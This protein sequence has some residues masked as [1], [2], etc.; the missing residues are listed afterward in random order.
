M[1]EPQTRGWSD[2]MTKI[3]HTNVKASNFMLSKAKKDR[4]I[5]IARSEEPGDPEDD[6]EVVDDDGQAKVLQEE[7][8]E[9]DENE[10]KKSSNKK[11]KKNNNNQTRIRP[12][13][14][15]MWNRES[16]LNA[17]ATKGVV[18]LFNAVNQHRKLISKSVASSGKSE[19]KRD[20]TLG[21]FSADTFMDILSSNKDGDEKVVKKK[22][23]FQ[24]V[25]LDEVEETKIGEWES[26][27]E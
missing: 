20:K 22:N 3:L 11:K 5:V 21:K 8:N 1:E 27:S 18:Q 25:L 4:D 10:V 14:R 24:D 15:N 6:L 26:D 23:R 9:S 7:S 19:R 17:L 12:E 2:A 13:R 16:E